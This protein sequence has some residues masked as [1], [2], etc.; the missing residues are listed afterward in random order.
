M[1]QPNVL[2]LLGDLIRIKSVNP[3]YEGGVPEAEMASF[4][5]SFFHQRDIRVQQQDVLPHR[6]NV[7]ATIPGKDRNRRI[8]LEAHMDTVATT[9]MQIDPFEPVVKEGNMFGRGTCDTKGPMAA[10]MCAMAKLA[11]S[12]I[13]P[14]VDVVFA[15]TVDE[16]FSY[17]GVAKYCEDLQADAAVV[18]EPT[19]LRQV[20]ASK[21]LVRF[22]IQTNG[23]AAH[24]AKPELGINAIEHMQ[25]VIAAIEKHICDLNSTTHPLLGSATCN[26]GV[27]RGGVQINLVPDRCEI[28]IDRRLLPGETPETALAEYQSLLDQI[29]QRV[30]NFEAKILPPLLTDVPLET[31][32]D[33]QP[34]THMNRILTDSGL[35]PDAIGV[36][37]CS[38]ASKFGAIGIPAIIFGPGSI[39]QAHAAIEYIEC[40]QVEQAVEIYHRFI[41]EYP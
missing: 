9:G 16:E 4:I 33:S 36:P 19:S 24:S 29:E 2:D 28:E 14:D 1:T 5:S 10:M 26:I 8:I 13:T 31:H 11:S 27:I 23:R 25:H 39:D 35:C 22:V 12:N 3:N 38:D 37:F 20:R 40:S 34:V 41:A 6:P 17:R 18:A 32:A 15:A 30:E 7:I 21:G